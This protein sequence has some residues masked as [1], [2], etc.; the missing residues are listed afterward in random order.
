MITA[1]MKIVV[2]HDNAVSSEMNVELDAISAELDG[3][4]EGREAILG[5]VARGTAVADAFHAT[6]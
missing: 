6:A 5:V 2:H 3:S 1:K 4:S